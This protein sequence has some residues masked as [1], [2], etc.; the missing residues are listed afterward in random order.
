MDLEVLRKA[1]LFTNLDDEVFAIL[2]SELTEAFQIGFLLFVPFIAVDMIVS[3]V[4]LAMGMQ[5]LSPT[6]ISLPFNLSLRRD[7]IQQAMMMLHMYW[8]QMTYHLLCS[9]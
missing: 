4:L 6:T 7:L 9:M 5:M 8:I 3:N 1:P 2:T